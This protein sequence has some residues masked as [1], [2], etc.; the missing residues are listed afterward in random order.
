MTSIPCLP[1]VARTTEFLSP[2][3]HPM[4]TSHFILLY[5]LLLKASTLLQYENKFPISFSVRTC[6]ENDHTFFSFKFQKNT[7]ALLMEASHSDS[8]SGVRW[9]WEG[10]GPAPHLA[11][12]K[13]NCMD[14]QI[15]PAS[16]SQSSV[17]ADMKINRKLSSCGPQ[18]LHIFPLLV[19]IPAE[20][21]D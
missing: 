8:E 3:L 7:A 15:A 1:R 2:P 11:Q 5:Y 6:V 4:L 13:N 19:C 10:K 20:F 14:P 17:A 12:R 18:M 16:P 9:K 21:N